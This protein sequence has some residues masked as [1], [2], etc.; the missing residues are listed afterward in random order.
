[1][2]DGKSDVEMDHING[3]Q[4]ALSNMRTPVQRHARVQYKTNRVKPPDVKQVSVHL[5]CGSV[6][7]PHGWHV[8]Q[9]YE[10]ERLHSLRA[11]S[12]LYKERDRCI[13]DKKTSGHDVSLTRCQPFR[14][15]SRETQ[16][17]QRWVFFE[18][19]ALP[20]LLKPRWLILECLPSPVELVFKQKK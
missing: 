15:T 11:S 5:T 20:N 8:R 16:H 18:R 1:M 2:R 19:H 6:Y 9:D 3:W 7:T 14:H 17:N 4:T 10:G 13:E 12:L